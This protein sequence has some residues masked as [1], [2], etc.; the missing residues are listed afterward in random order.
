MTMTYEKIENLLAQIV[1]TED[2]N[3]SA[4][5][6]ILDDYEREYISGLFNRDQFKFSNIDSND[7]QIKLNALTIF[8]YK[9]YNTPDL[10]KRYFDNRPEMLTRLL[11]I[12]FGLYGNIIREE[13]KTYEIRDVV[14]TSIYGI[15]SDKVVELDHSLQQY[16]ASQCNIE[17]ETK[18]DKMF[19]DTWVLFLYLSK[20]IASKIDLATINTLSSS[21]DKALNDLQDEM[22]AQEAPSIQDGIHISIIANLIYIFQEYYYYL[23]HGK[24]SDG[25]R[26]LDKLQT[27]MY[28]AAKYAELIND[29]KTKIIVV[30]LKTALEKLYQRSLW[31]IANITPA[32]HQFISHL[33][34]EQDKFILNLLPSQQKVASDLFSSKKSVVINMPTSAG[35]TLLAQLYIL[36]KMQQYQIGNEFPLACYVVPTNALINQIKKK[37]EKDYK[38]LGFT[39]ETVLPFYQSDE[40]ENQILQEKNINILIVTPEK[41]DFMI[42]SDHPALKKLRLI[43]MDEAHNIAEKTRGSKFELLLAGIKQE[44]P[45]IDFLLL[46]P[47][48]ENAKEIAEWLGDSAFN[49]V[50]ISAE[51][52][53]NKQFIG[54]FHHT[55]TVA[56]I[57]YVPSARNNIVVDKVIIP[58]SNNPNDIK[59]FMHDSSI[60]GIHRL[61]PLLEQYKLMGNILVLCE[62]PG[63]TEKYAKKFLAYLQ[64]KN[65]PR[66]NAQNI[67]IR[68]AIGIIKLEQEGHDTLIECLEYGVAYHHARM[69]DLIKSTIEELMIDQNINLLFATTT[70]AQGMNFP[71]TTVIFDFYKR[72]GASEKI[73]ANDFWNIAGRAGRAFIDNEGHILLKQTKADDSEETLG[74]I[75]RDYIE[76]DIKD[77]MSSLVDFFEQIDSSTELNLNFLETPAATNFVQYLNHILRVVHNYNFQLD[78][79]SLQ[80]ILNN[81]L[82]YSQQSKRFGFMESQAKVRGFCN[83]YI[84]HLKEKTPASLKLAD[85]SGISDISLS[86]LYSEYRKFLEQLKADNANTDVNKKAS[87]LILNSENPHY[88][89]QIIYM[90][91]QIP[92]FK[93]SFGL[94]GDQFNSEMIAQMVISWVG[95]DSIEKI[96]KDNYKENPK[97]DFNEFLSK[98][99]KYI[100]STMK[101]FI[102]WGISVYQTVSDD[103]Q[104][105]RS[106]N[107][108][109]FIYYGVNNTEMAILSKIGVPRSA[110]K[111]VKSVLEKE[112]F[113]QITIENMDMIK[114]TF[115]A[116][117]LN[118]YV[119]HAGETGQTIYQLVQKI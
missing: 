103:R 20:N 83:K 30:L 55:N 60:S 93:L 73:P 114:Q 25:G 99:N 34:Q 116:F 63:N 104:D 2:S 26:F 64:K 81:S 80:T 47:F 29:N 41:L 65:T 78:T 90:L 19:N 33:I 92:E 97:V 3:I 49:S 23:L 105:T 5:A 106:A 12:A 43:V 7:I 10:N 110:L 77:I 91:N 101:N 61:I 48:I 67:A 57:T 54:Y 58:I 46:S 18:I 74:Q 87:N 112:G 109:S 42:R 13:P 22:L 52:T 88:L 95:G 118:T 1:N 68:D 119:K 51:W 6:S 100:N 84:E 4:V 28:N 113:G 59:N 102:P 45:D 14:L 117:N 53:P 36:Y 82:V 50:G 69:S 107:L 16:L 32:I 31:Q 94:N 17:K 115:K 66:I 98:C 56:N 11:E 111:T 85:L 15:L 27:Y 72:R 44:R 39:I 37:F 40:L 21:I 8:I 70:L 89:G 76:T 62:S 75:T 38:G 9:I 35:K 24:L 71:V 79:A 86:K 108:P 96:A